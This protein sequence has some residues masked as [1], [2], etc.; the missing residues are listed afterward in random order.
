VRAE[1]A[2]VLIEF[3]QFG[4]LVESGDAIKEMLESEDKFHRAAVAALVSRLRLQGRTQFLLQLLRDPE[5]EV[6]LAALKESGSASEAAL[7][8]PVISQLGDGRTADAA[9]EALTELGPLT[10]DYFLE[11]PNAAELAA[12][13]CQ[14]D[15]LP[16]IL[17]K[18]GTPGALQVLKRVLDTT[19]SHAPSAV[20]RAYSRI[21]QRQPRFA[22]HQKHWESVVLC[23]VKAARQRRCMLAQAASLAK[24]ALLM[25]VLREE[26]ERH[27]DHV[28]LLIGSRARGVRM[29][30]IHAQLNSRR[31]EERIHALE[32]LEHVVPA[33][34]RPEIMGLVDDKRSSSTGNG[35]RP[36]LME[37]LPAETSEPILLSALYSV[38]QNDC[39]DA[40]PL[41]RKYLSHDSRVVRETA[42]HT[43]A[44]MEASDS[45]IPLGGA[46]PQVPDAG[47]RRNQGTACNLQTPEGG[48]NM[49]TVEK[50]L[51]LGNV[52]LF[53]KIGTQEV[54]HIAS[55]AREASYPAGHPIIR[56]GEYGDHMFLIVDGEVQIHHGQTSV[57][58]LGPSEFF[59]EMSIIDGEPR[60][61]SVTAFSDCL[62]LRIDKEDFH[63]LLSTHGSVA[64]SMIRVLVQRLRGLL[65]ALER[66]EKGM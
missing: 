59:G 52:P 10:V 56:E 37:I 65:P 58:M 32:F 34:L 64:L 50:M 8:P 46:P 43:I 25:R 27:L 17:A 36:L 39:R 40:L 22:P 57:K 16:H 45:A 18:I 20:I 13:F 21:L 6:R 19:S 31:E 55:I 30:E 5:P 51:F 66:V 48:A 35:A 4:G 60:S 63:E 44:R 62:L 41:V 38:L 15:R 54:A 24:N 33:K 14:S 9:A 12:M 61:A 53:S 49:I 42:E 47:F 28:F 1:A 29:E 3:G 11:T 2:S 26:C 23:Q 7:I